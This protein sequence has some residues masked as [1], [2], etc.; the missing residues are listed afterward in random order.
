M[1]R[2]RLARVQDE[3]VAAEVDNVAASV[4]GGVECPLLTHPDV[5][6]C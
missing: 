5:A 4:Q 3:Q 6:G 2:V 1:G